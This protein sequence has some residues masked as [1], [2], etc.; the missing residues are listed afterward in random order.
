MTD[1][2]KTLRFP[3]ME[4]GGDYDGDLFQKND[5]GE[6]IP[7]DT[8]RYDD[9]DDFSESGSVEPDETGEG[10]GGEDKSILEGERAAYERIKEL[11]AGEDD[12]TYFPADSAEENNQKYAM[13]ELRTAWGAN[14]GFNIGIARSFFK[15]FLNENLIREAHVTGI[16][17]HPLMVLAFYKAAKE[18]EQ[19]AANQMSGDTGDGLKTLKFRGMQEITN[20]KLEERCRDLASQIYSRTMNEIIRRH[21][22]INYA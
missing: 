9:D 5:K 4:G 3:S 11:T 14:T 10:G 17:S 18:A 8:Y 16:A 2:E 1:T 21:G 19:F 13:R 7:Y 22:A 6:Y 15:N 12:F 20:R